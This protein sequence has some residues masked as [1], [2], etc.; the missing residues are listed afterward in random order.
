MSDIMINIDLIT[1]N[2]EEMTW[3]SLSQRLSLISTLPNTFSALFSLESYLAL[4]RQ[5]KLVIIGNIMDLWIE[6]MEESTSIFQFSH[7]QDKDRVLHLSLWNF[8]GLLLIL[9]HWSPKLTLSEEDLSMATFWIQLHGLPMAGMNRQNILNTGATV[10]TLVDMETLP[11][12]IFCK[13]FFRMRFSFNACNPLKVGFSFPRPHLQAA[14]IR[15]RHQKLVD[16]C[17]TCGCVNHSVSMCPYDEAAP[18]V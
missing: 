9:Q 4:N 7:S 18:S 13:R 8:K 15:F 14:F 3:E 17:Y 10:G 1:Y 16:F 12:G 2:M 11:D 6:A 5:E